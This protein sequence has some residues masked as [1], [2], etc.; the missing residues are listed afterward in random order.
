MIAKQWF[1]Q[2]QK[3]AQSAGSGTRQERPSH[4]SWLKFWSSGVL[5]SLGSIGHLLQPSD[6]AL[7]Y[8]QYGDEGEAALDRVAEAARRS[9]HK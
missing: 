5:V 4:T 2:V 3:L 7:K 9:Q 8:Q 6:E 1:R